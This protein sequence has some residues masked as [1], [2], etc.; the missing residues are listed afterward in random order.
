MLSHGSVLFHM[1][2]V[3]RTSESWLTLLL[4]EG[5]N[6]CGSS[7]FYIHISKPLTAFA[8]KLNLDIILWQIVDCT[9]FGEKIFSQS[10]HPKD[11]LDVVGCL[12][13]LL[14]GMLDTVG[15]VLA[16]HSPRDEIGHS[17]A[18]WVGLT[19]G[20]RHKVAEHTQP[21]AAESQA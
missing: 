8:N 19:S 12:V 1:H 4:Q 18:W 14:S 2:R 13:D 7:W 3:A 16:L 6:R 20:L 10:S 9:Y 11:N 15:F 5:R 21:F 17:C